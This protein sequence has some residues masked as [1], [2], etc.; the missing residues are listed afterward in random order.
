MLGPFPWR[1]RSAEAAPAERE[2]ALCSTPS[3]GTS[4]CQRWHLP[5]Q[6]EA[7]TPGNRQPQPVRAPDLSPAAVQHSP[8]PHI[9]QAATAAGLRVTH[10]EAP[11][12]LAKRSPLPGMG[13]S[14]GWTLCFLA[15]GS[16]CSP[17]PA[18]GTRTHPVP[19]VDGIKRRCK[20]PAALT[21]SQPPQGFH[22]KWIPG[23]R[24]F[25]WRKLTLDC[26]G[27]S[28]AHPKKLPA[29]REQDTRTS[30]V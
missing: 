24:G 19:C 30:K 28:E 21:T 27:S 17:R 8:A 4:C 20:R 26:H 2:L 10:E 14:A 7:F 5:R 15:Q 12:G 16:R 23:G 11:W 3:S 9:G 29:P 6:V 22:R 1:Q 18:A 13:D 25:R